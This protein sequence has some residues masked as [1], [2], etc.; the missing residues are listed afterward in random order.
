MINWSNIDTV[1]DALRTQVEDPQEN[2]WDEIFRHLQTAKTMFNAG[3]P[4]QETMYFD[5][6]PQGIQFELA[7]IVLVILQFC[8][9][10][11]INLSK[12][13]ETVAETS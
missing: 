8:A 11:N 7:S 10:K 2:V 3:W 9:D 4:E 13:I 6:K 5:D 1:I 12:A